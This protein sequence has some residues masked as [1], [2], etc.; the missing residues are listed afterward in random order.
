ML[1]TSTT[2]ISSEL[3]REAELLS[4]Q[5]LPPGWE[6]VNSS[7]NAS[8]AFH[9]GRQ[10]YYK[11]FLPRSPLEKIKAVVRGSR[12]T[13]ARKNDDALRLAGIEAPVNIA[14]GKLSGGREYLFNNAI[15]GRGVT[16]W[17]R[18]ELV[19][20]SGE[21]LHMRRELLHSL[22]IFIGRL[23]ATGF[24]HGDLRGGNVLATREGG[25]FQFAL[26]DNERNVFS[27]P[28]AGKRLLRNLMQLNMLQP[29]DLSRTD[30]MRFFLAWHSQMRELNKTEA[31]VV[32]NRAYQ[33]AS[34]RMSG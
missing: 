24:T 4:D 13:R 6:M 3:Q 29:S 5:K 18:C 10:L 14:W 34:R 7:A 11:E 17:L 21:A 8:V 16:D 20:R 26:I 25:R 30:R 32:A 33:W 9:P 1:S 12:A 19:E 28:A 15:P 31:R 2:P 22:G 27:R 23:H